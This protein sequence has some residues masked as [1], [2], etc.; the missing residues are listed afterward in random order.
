LRKHLRNPAHIKTYFPALVRVTQRFAGR[1][2]RAA[3]AGV[4]R[5]HGFITLGHGQMSEQNEY[6]RMRRV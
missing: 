2:K 1:W 5:P 3:A 6:G 4:S